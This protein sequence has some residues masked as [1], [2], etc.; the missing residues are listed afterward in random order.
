MR[1]CSSLMKK[2]LVSIHTCRAALSENR[3]RRNGI[4]ME[5]IISFAAV[6]ASISTKARSAPK[7]RNAFST[8]L[9]QSRDKSLMTRDQLSANSES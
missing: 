9:A 8:L 4:A 5:N 3:S 2:R 1:T 6:T 7:V